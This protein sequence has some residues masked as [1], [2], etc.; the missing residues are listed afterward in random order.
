MP[1]PRKDQKILRG[2]GPGSFA[3]RFST[4]DE[5]CS[6]IETAAD[7]GAKL[8]VL[9]R[10]P[11]ERFVSCAGAYFRNRLLYAMHFSFGGHEDTGD[12]R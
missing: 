10:A 7:A 5:D 11:T 12:K 9:P 3:K 8:P 2:A 6:A 1:E 4:A